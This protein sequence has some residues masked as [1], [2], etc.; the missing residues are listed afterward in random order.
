MA[1]T[2]SADNAKISRLVLVMSPE[3]VEGVI[4][5]DVPAQLL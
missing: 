4:A 1:S 2:G 5:I 3:L